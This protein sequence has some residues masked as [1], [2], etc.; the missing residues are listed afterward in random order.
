[1]KVQ[2]GD[3][4]KV[5]LGKDNGK[6]GKVLRVYSKLGQVLVEGVNL[7]KRHVRRMGQHEGGILDIAKPVNASNVMVVCPECKKTT[8]VGYKVENDKKMRVCKHCGK[9][10][11]VKETK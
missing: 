7:S 10:L 1:M 3:T 11:A 6:T 8:R 4:V 2:T 5:M 9:A